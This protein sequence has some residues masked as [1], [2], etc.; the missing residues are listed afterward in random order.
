MTECPL[1]AVCSLRHPREPG[2]GERELILKRETL[3]ATINAILEHLHRYT[4]TLETVDYTILVAKTRITAVRKRLEAK[5][6]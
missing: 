4:Q 2:S 1:Y 5:P 6:D 3:K